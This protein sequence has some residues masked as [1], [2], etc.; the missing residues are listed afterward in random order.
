MLYLVHTR[1]V[2]LMIFS[3]NSKNTSSLLK[4]TEVDKLYPRERM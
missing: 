2:P 1:V 4:K 3:S